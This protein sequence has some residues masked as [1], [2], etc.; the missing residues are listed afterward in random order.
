MSRVTATTTYSR[1]FPWWRNQ[2]QRTLNARLNEGELSR[3]Y[4]LLSQYLLPS[5]L[6]MLTSDGDTETLLN[7]SAAEGDVLLSLHGTHKVAIEEE[8]DEETASHQEENDKFEF[9]PFHLFIKTTFIEFSGSSDIFFKAYREDHGIEKLSSQTIQ[10]VI[11]CPDIVLEKVVFSMGFYKPGFFSASLNITPEL[12]EGILLNITT[13]QFYGHIWNDKLK[14]AH[15]EILS[16]P[17]ATSFKNFIEEVF[18]T[19]AS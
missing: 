1:P 16:E 11:T 13:E 14:G 3:S 2:G 19:H 12:V 5:E 6:S 8:G 10:Q 17:W 15:T 18:P 7:A 4:Q 9:V